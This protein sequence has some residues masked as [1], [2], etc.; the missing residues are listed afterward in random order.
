MERVVRLAW[1]GPRRVSD[2]HGLGSALVDRGGTIA[3]IVLTSDGVAV[4][5]GYATRVADDFRRLGRVGHS[6]AGIA[7]TDRRRG[8]VVTSVAA[9][10]P[11][12]VAGLRPGDLI[13]SVNGYAVGG[14]AEVMAIV[15][16]HWPGDRLRFA[17]Q[18][19]AT[20]SVLDVATAQAPDFKPSG[21]T[22]TSVT[23]V[24]SRR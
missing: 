9:S 7:G 19:D 1:A 21:V 22:P 3:G 15:H 16:S 24:A 8:A 12:A 18:R 10:G 4:P 5:I 20:Q 14:M 11:A 17:V 2:A 6:W 13:L 23:T